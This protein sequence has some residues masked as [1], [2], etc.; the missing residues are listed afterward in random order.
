MKEDIEVKMAAV[1]APT[2]EN[3]SK[4]I[5]LSAKKTNKRRTYKTN[6]NKSEEQRRTTITTNTTLA[7]QTD[8]KREENI[9]LRI[10]SSNCDAQAAT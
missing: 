10:H 6:T 8:K 5:T 4:V 1:L 2:P 3:V 9:Q 7:D